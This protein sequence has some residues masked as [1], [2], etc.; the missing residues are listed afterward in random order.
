MVRIKRVYAPPAQEDGV[1]ILVERLWPRGVS[2]DQAGLSRWEKDL[3]PSPELRRWFSHDPQKWPEFRRRYWAELDAKT[4]QILQLRTEA[5]TG[6]V[7]L[8]YAARDE[9]HNAALALQQYLG[10]PQGAA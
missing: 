6:P 9:Q 7:T 4:A 3:A 8:V 5:D 2:K 10:G 1:R